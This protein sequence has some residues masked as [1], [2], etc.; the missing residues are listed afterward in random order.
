MLRQERKKMKVKSTIRIDELEK[1]IIVKIPRGRRVDFEISESGRLEP[2]L[3][4]SDY[5]FPEEIPY[6]FIG[7]VEFPDGNLYPKYKANMVSKQVLWFYGK[8]S[9]ENAIDIINKIANSCI[10][11]HTT[12][13]TAISAAAG[14]P[15]GLILMATI[16]A[17][18]AQY[19]WHVFVLAQKLAYLYGFPDLRDKDGNL[20]DTAC[21][22]LT[23][24][25]GVMMGT[26][27]ANQAIRGIAKG[28][29]EQVAKRLPQQALT[30]TTWYP[31]VKNVAKWIGVK[32]TKD[33]TA[34]GVGKI[35]P[36]LSAVISGVLTLATFRPCAKR[37]QRKLQETALVQ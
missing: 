5:F 24:F 18:L 3:F 30:K 2:E 19:Y 13:V 6:E 8:A 12:K 4:F 25:V 31:L 29:A 37:L 33:V 1:E 34:K 36:V 32:L 7:L 21:D 14:L 22:M 11:S 26:S 17:D 15:G 27:A 16:P 20:T 9:Y 23:L 35:I 10:N 28:L